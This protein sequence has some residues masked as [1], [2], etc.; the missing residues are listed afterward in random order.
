MQIVWADLLPFTLIFNK[1]TAFVVS[2]CWSII[3]MLVYVELFIR[4]R[5]TLM[6]VLDVLF[7][8]LFA[9]FDGLMCD[10]DT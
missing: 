10:L 2:I 6:S 3:S 8:V 1:I 9:M 5:E 4:S 7:G